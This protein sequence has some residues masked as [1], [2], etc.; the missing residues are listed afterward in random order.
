M[1]PAY[2]DP[3][4]PIDETSPLFRNEYEID[5]LLAGLV[6]QTHY[7]LNMGNDFTE[8]SSSFASGGLSATKQRPQDSNVLEPTLLIYLQNARVYMLQDYSGNT[9]KANY[10]ACDE[11]AKYATYEEGDKR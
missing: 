8:G 9:P 7:T 2:R 5:Q 11:L 4:V 3:P 6:A 10:N 1:E